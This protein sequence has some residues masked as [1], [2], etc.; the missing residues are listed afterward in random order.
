MLFIVLVVVDSTAAVHDVQEGSA[1][2]K[3]RQGLCVSSAG[4]AELSAG[5][6]CNREIHSVSRRTQFGKAVVHIGRQ[7]GETADSLSDLSFHPEHTLRIHRASHRVVP[8]RLNR[9]GYRTNIP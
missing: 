9:S 8:C 2:P 6:V 1:L 5:L 7:F 4:L 3:H